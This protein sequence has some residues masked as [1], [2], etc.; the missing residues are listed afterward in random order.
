MRLDRIKDKA[1]A[2]YLN[3][4]VKRHPY[5]ILWLLVIVLSVDIVWGIMPGL[6]EA[7]KAK[8]QIWEEQRYRQPRT[9][10][11]SAEL[12]RA[13]EEEQRQRRGGRTG[14]K[15][16]VSR[17]VAHIQGLKPPQ[18]CNFLSKP[19]CVCLFTRTRFPPK[20]HF[21]CFMTFHFFVESHF[22]QSSTSQGLV[23]GHWFSGQDSA[24]LPQPE[25]NLWLE[26]RPPPPSAC[27]QPK[28]ASYH[29]SCLSRSS[30]DHRSPVYESLKHKGLSAMFSPEPPVPETIPT[31]SRHAKPLCC[32]HEWYIDDDAP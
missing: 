11:E 8:Y 1:L 27:S 3:I 14:C 22:L 24:L 7:G 17:E 21:T 4:G 6:E 29:S 12:A 28:I 20:E 10:Q 16:A 9:Q 31:H 26:L 15:G 25:F 32:T 2:W 19:A 30:V 13:L 5:Y 23:T 18:E